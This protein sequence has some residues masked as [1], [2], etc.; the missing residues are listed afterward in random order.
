MMSFLPNGP[1]RCS[2]LLLMSTLALAGC[3][4]HAK[5]TPPPVEKTQIIVDTPYDLTWDATIAVIKNN[6]YH[7]QA[8]DPVHGVLEVQSNHFS[9]ADVDCGTISSIGGKYPVEPDPGDSAVYNFVVKPNGSESSTVAVQ[10]T[11]DVS[12][13]VPFHPIGDTVCI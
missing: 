6:N 4:Y 12:L 10:A 3:F 1:R 13:R 8:Q 11:F 2:A 5:G 7:L 9:L